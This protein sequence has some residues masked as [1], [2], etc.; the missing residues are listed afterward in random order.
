MKFITVVAA[1]LLAAAVPRL[2]AAQIGPVIDALP[3]DEA[4]VKGVIDQ[5]PG[6]ATMTPLNKVRALRVYVFQ[7]TPLAAVNDFNI[8]TKV[9]NLPL[10]DAYTAFDANEG[11][12]WCSGT[13]I[14]LVRVYK[15]AGFNAWIYDFGQKDV[16]TH[17]TTLVEVDGKVYLQDAY[18]NFE[19]MDSKGAPIEFLDVVKRVRDGRPPLVRSQV[20]TKKAFFTNQSNAEEWVGIHKDKMTCTPE[21]RGLECEAPITLSRFL[22]V[23][24]LMD[25]TYDFLEARGWPRQV[26]YLLLYPMGV[27]SLY[28]DTVEKGQSIRATIDEIAQTAGRDSA[29]VTSG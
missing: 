5:I 17:A 6:Y 19:Y 15:A 26:D 11:G 10:K 20:Q 25:K 18:L 4:Y 3:Q 14:M 9:V 29:M 13:A 21:A 23:F 12:V 28:S 8:H 27:V 2:A 1:A 22:E 7:K 24:F 16:L